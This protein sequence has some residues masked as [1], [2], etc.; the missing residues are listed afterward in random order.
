MVSY[1]WYLVPIH[2]KNRPQVACPCTDRQTDWRQNDA[3]NGKIRRHGLQRW[4]SSYSKNGSEPW[5]PSLYS[6]LQA[7][8]IISLLSCYREGRRKRTRYKIQS[9]LRLNT[10]IT[11]PYFVLFTA[12]TEREIQSQN[13]CASYRITLTSNLWNKPQRKLVVI[14]Q[15]SQREII[16]RH[17]NFRAI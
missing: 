14:R 7:I 13:F 8:E 17:K 15:I 2:H 10:S 6:L 4:H 3:R 12:F 11:Y 5:I 16:T 9:A 1:I